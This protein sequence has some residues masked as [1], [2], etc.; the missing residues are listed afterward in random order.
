[1]SR[2]RTVVV[3]DEPLARGLIVTLLGRDREVEVVGEC[4]DGARAAALIRR[5]RPDIAFLD[6]EMPERGG[7][8]VAAELPA[9]ALPAVVFV[10]AYGEH[11]L[12]AFELSALDYVLKPFSDERFYD[13]LER[14]KRRIRERRLGELAGKVA[15]LATELERRPAGPGAAEPYLERL[16]VRGGGRA[17]IV[18]VEDLVWIETQ[19]Y[20]V[21]LH[22]RQGKLLLRA[23]LNALEARLD[24]ARF[25]RV[26]RTALV[27]LAHVREVRQ[28]FK[29]RRR[30]LLSDGT[31]LPVSRERRQRLESALFPDLRAPRG[32]A[33]AR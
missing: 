25:L 8:E 18:K 33:D 3:D 16:A 29:G 17:H 24:P 11:A 1:M 22:T 12:R 19:D 31:E 32:G 5:L 9:D 15:D 7:L 28:L 23:S 21:R 4:G 26:H 6:I 2:F 14:A 20:C 13:A 27:H 30:V 10:T